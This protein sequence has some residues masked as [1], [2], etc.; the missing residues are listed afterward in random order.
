MKSFEKHRA[1]IARVVA[2]VAALIFSVS[3]NLSLAKTHGGSGSSSDDS[4]SGGSNSSSNSSS[5]SSNSSGAH[6]S[7]PVSGAHPYSGPQHYSGVHPS[8]TYRPTTTSSA[9]TRTFSYPTVHGTMVPIKA[10]PVTPHHISSTQHSQ[11]KQNPRSQSQN[12]SSTLTRSN[13][14]A[15]NGGHSK[16]TSAQLGKSAHNNF[17]GKSKLDPQTAAQLRHW[18]GKTDSPAQARQ[19]NREFRNAHHDRGW[20]RRHCVAIIFLDFGWWGW[21]DGWWYPAWGYDPYYNYYA[22]DQ[23]IYGYNGLAP[24]Q[25]VANVQ[26]ALQQLGY[27]N[28]AVDGVM[29]PLT[30]AAIANYQRDHLL[31]ITAGIDPATLGSLGLIY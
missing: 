6:S 28:Y 25:V 5:S 27:Y 22:Y 24:D 11:F 16:P 12:K 3:G 18:K 7:G 1:L 23:P 14:T 13:A 19:N 26:G 10:R 8:P 29:G 2:F 9:G 20:W 21:W 15:G 17:N 4:S 31:P 30:S